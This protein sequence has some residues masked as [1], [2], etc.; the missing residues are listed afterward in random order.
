MKD[1]CYNCGRDA[2]TLCSCEVYKCADESCSALADMRY[3]PCEGNEYC[4]YHAQKNLER[5]D[6]ERLNLVHHNED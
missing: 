4:S 6:N 5:L 1:H 2:K 3:R